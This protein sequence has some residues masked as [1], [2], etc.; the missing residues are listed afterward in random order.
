MAPAIESGIKKETAALMTMDKIKEA[1]LRIDEVESELCRGISLHHTI[2]SMKV[3]YA[4][5]A[6]KTYLN[7]RTFNT[8]EYKLFFSYFMPG[9]T[10]GILE[11][12]TP[13]SQPLLIMQQVRT[14]DGEQKLKSGKLP[15]YKM[16]SFPNVLTLKCSQVPTSKRFNST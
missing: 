10:R 11:L 1:S 3:T 2:K 5:V 16:N 12:A 9:F 7:D 14:I 8:L 4:L 6:K 15:Y 13:S